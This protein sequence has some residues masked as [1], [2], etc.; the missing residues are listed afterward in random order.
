MNNMVHVLKKKGQHLRVPQRHYHV[1]RCDFLEIWSISVFTQELN[2]QICI[3]SY[4]GQLQNRT[5]TK[6]LNLYIP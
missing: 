3:C 5:L 1:K 4:P 2:N 6:L